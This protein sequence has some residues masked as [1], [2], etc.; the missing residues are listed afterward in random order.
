MLSERLQHVPIVSHFRLGTPWKLIT[1]GP[2][3]RCVLRHQKHTASRC[4][5]KA[6][7][8]AA[9]LGQHTVDNVKW[10]VHAP[11][12]LLGCIAQDGANR[13]VGTC[14]YG[15][16]S[17]FSKAAE[18]RLCHVLPWL[19]RSDL[20]QLQ[21][22]SLNVAENEQQR[23]LSLACRLRGLWQDTDPEDTNGI[24]AQ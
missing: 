9:G 11:S 8:G 21:M 10:V 4:P 19:D 2:R 17:L 15:R 24:L 18:P 22:A 14:R 5:G 1:S 20:H 13:R 3:R 6:L 23:H 12:L 7:P 16:R